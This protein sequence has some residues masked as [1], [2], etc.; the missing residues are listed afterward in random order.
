MTKHLD[1]TIL[2]KLNVKLT[3]ISNLLREGRLETSVVIASY[4]KCTII[5]K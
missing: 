1:S 3:E 2:Y 5:F 4:K